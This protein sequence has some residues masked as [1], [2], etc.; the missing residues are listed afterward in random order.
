MN[1]EVRNA[2][3]NLSHSWRLSVGSVSLAWQLRR[4]FGNVRSVVGWWLAVASS[5]LENQTSLCVFLVAV[6]NPSGCRTPEV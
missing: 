6:N 2:I 3:K 1:L 5:L 4:T